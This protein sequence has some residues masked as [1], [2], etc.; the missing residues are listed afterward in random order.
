MPWHGLCRRKSALHRIGVH[1][2]RF[3]QDAHLV[4]SSSIIPLVSSQMCFAHPSPL[5]LV[6]QSGRPTRSALPVFIL[7]IFADGRGA[8]G[9]AVAS[10]ETAPGVAVAAPRARRSATQERALTR[11]P[12]RL[13]SKKETSTV[14]SDARH[15]CNMHVQKR[16]K[17]KY[18]D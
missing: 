2:A 9:T 15:T 6:S 11:N 1:H 8:D 7:F 10:Q 12:S 4:L 13:Q 17:K 14:G 3:Q 5:P 16:K 18:R